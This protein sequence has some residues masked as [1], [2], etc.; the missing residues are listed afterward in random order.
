MKKV[1]KNEVQEHEKCG[2]RMI[3][4]SEASWLTVNSL[5]GKLEF[6]R[7]WLHCR[8]CHEGYAPFDKQLGI[9]KEH[10]V[11]KGLVETICDLAQRMGSFEEASYMLDKYLGINMAPSMVQEISEEVGKALYEKEK[12]E[13]KELYENQHKTVSQVPE[14][15]KKGRLYIEADG[16]MIQ[17]RGEGYKEVKLGMVFKDNKILNKDK[18]RHKIIEKDYVSSFDGAEEFKK[19]LWA[20]AVKN[21]YQDV[22]EVVILGDGAGW[23]WNMA[24]ELFPDAVFILD[25]YHFEEHVHECANV[26][27]PDDKISRKTWVN[28]II[29]GFMNDRIEPTIEK[30][31]MEKFTEPKVGIKVEELKTYLGNNKDKMNYKV[32]KDKGYFIGSGAIEGGNKH[33]I[34]Q[35]LKLAGMRWNKTGAQYIASLRCASKGDKWGKVTEV[36]YSEAC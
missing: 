21:G 1:K 30:L 23:I 4:T 29:D 5:M 6:H 16:S 26:I 28:K 3:A 36:V 32:Y 31:S 17:I 27:Y 8:R 9:N 13:A 7:W 14:N 22:K 18:E 19:M 34:Q 12:A 10:K 20:V 15:V 2:K 35:R 24:K 33:V 25:Y 11:T